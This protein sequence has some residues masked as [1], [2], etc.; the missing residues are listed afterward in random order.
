MQMMLTDRAALVP[1][2]NL[3]Q[4]PNF[5]GRTELAR[6]LAAFPTAPN[7]FRGA[8]IAPEVYNS[9]SGLAVTVRAELKLQGQSNSL[10]PDI[11][12]LFGIAHLLDRNPFTLSGGEQALLAMAAASACR[13]QVC[14]IDGASEQL[15]PGAKLNAMHALK[16]LIEG[17]I[18]L[19]DNRSRELDGLANRIIL[20]KH[21][22]DQL[23]RVTADHFDAGEIQPLHVHL[24]NVSFG[25]IK[26][27]TIIKNVSLELTPGN[28]YCFL[29]KVGAGKSTLAKLLVG[30]L[31]PQQGTLYCGSQKAKP[32]NAPGRIFS[33]HFQ[34]PDIQL[35]AS[36]VGEEVTLATRNL[37]AAERKHSETF[38]AS[39]GLQHLL[40]EHP[41]DLPFVLRKRAALLATVC[42]RTPWTI[43]D[44][45]TLGQDDETCEEI[46]RIINRIA[47]SGGGVIVISHSAWFRDRLNGVPILLERLGVPDMETA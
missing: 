33:Y 45:P 23:C 35:F 24:E 4:G 12:S 28:I 5:S 29:G 32:W 44:E 39:F 46:I 17:A 21:Q 25:Y 22:Q 9:L 31:R 3:L 40:S 37:K 27:K 19:C 7:G 10:A 13:P 15:D 43:F 16:R 6:Q 20:R 11:P 18:V 34:N 38:I 30:I 42:M 47:G 36:T 14:A 26:N 41:L 2:L 8:Y 1:G